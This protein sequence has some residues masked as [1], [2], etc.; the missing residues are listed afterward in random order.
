MPYVIMRPQGLARNSEADIV[1]SPHVLRRSGSV[2][3]H[4]TCDE[5][6]LFIF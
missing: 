1:A 5:C 2:S 3:E 4:L 6:F